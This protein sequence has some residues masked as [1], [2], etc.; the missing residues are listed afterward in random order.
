M[1]RGTTMWQLI[2]YQILVPAE[3]KLIQMFLCK[4]YITPTFD[5]TWEKSA[6]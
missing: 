3:L 4:K 1:R 2:H 6:R 5:K